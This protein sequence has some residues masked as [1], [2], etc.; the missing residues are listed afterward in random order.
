MNKNSL[1]ALIQNATEKYQHSPYYIN[2]GKP[3]YL[4]LQS[5]SDM[6]FIEPESIQLDETAV[7]LTLFK[8][9]GFELANITGFKITLPYQSIFS[10]LTITYED[11]NDF[12]TYEATVIRVSDETLPILM[13]Y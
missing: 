10:V 12:G 5:D 8:M 2:T 13:P 7:T 6:W 9:R 3:K 4:R 1:Q 11:N